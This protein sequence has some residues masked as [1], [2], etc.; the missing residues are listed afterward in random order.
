MNPS[1][2][3]R[4]KPSRKLR[5]AS[6]RDRRGSSR[7]GSGSR[8][9]ESVWDNF[10]PHF[11]DELTLHETVRGFSDHDLAQLQ[12]LLTV[13]SFGQEVCEALDASDSL[14][15]RVARDLNVDMR[16]H[17]QPD[18]GFFG[19]RSREQLIDIAIECGYAL[20]KGQVSGYKKLDLVNALA[21]FFQNAKAAAEATL[22]QIKAREWLP[23][24]MLFPAIDRNAPVDVE[25]ETEA[26]DEEYD[27][28]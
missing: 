1:G 26:V 24:A 21:R 7:S 14:F 15:N 13:L 28:D 12:T 5:T 16:R 22:Q 8:E 17:W 11:T 25:R 2:L 23:E 3:W 20:G 9:G 27:E 10:P 18:A 6:W 4:K 19:K